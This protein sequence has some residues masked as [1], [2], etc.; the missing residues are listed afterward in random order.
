M[1]NQY[2]DLPALFKRQDKKARKWIAGWMIEHD[3]E[4]NSDNARLQSYVDGKK[5]VIH[6]DDYCGYLEHDHLMPFLH[7]A[8]SQGILRWDLL[9]SAA[10]YGLSS[11]LVSATL[12]ETEPRMS[13]ALLSKAALMVGL[14]AVAGWQEEARVLFQA[15]HRGMGNLFLNLRE[16]GTQDDTQ[17]YFLMLLAADY[18]DCP[19]DRETYYFAEDEAMPAYAAALEHWRSTDLDL[20]QR[21]VTDMADHHVRNTQSA[22]PDAIAPFAIESLWLFPYEILAFLRFREWVGLENP[23]SFTH[24]L[25]NTPVA[26][27]PRT[28]LPWPEIPLLDQALA[29]FKGEYPENN[30][31][32]LLPDHPA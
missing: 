26:V 24:P 16:D 2:I 5:D 14:T 4:L 10:R 32:N 15:M 12:A 8:L 27:L 18:F 20:V 13:S 25:M 1:K 9:A 31:F 6:L 19:I 28:S 7:A 22:E 21:L 3:E 29:K 30:A 11:M 23:A 17:F